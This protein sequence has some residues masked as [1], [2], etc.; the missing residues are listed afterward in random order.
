LEL[1]S[2]LLVYTLSH[3]GYLSASVTATRT[4]NNVAG[5]DVTNFNFQG[6]SGFILTGYNRLEERTPDGTPVRNVTFKE[7]KWDVTAGNNS[8]RNLHYVTLKGKNPG[9]FGFE[10]KVLEQGED[11][12]FT[13]LV[14]EVLGKVTFG[15]VYTFVTPKSMESILEVNNWSYKNKANNLVFI[16]GVA[17]GAA[18]GDSVGS[19][20]FA[21]GS[22]DNQVYAHFSGSAD[23]NG[24]AKTVTVT[25][26]VEKDWGLVTDD[27]TIQGQVK[28]TYNSS[29]ALSR[30]EVAFKAGEAAILYD[31]AIGSGQPLV[32]KEEA[33]TGNAF[34]A[35]FSVLLFIASMLF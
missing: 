30:F 6:S 9:I 28:A 21:S 17:T 14:A 29:F 33:G 19:V 23:Y 34:V 22:G 15:S 32:P 16:G 1:L 31:P 25:K 20:T 11:V 10:K 13:F 5:T 2:F 24:K 26:S 7:L 3:L 18:V 12:S 27:V 8:A 4:I 35:C